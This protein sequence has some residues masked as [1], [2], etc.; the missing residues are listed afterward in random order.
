MKN[1][2]ELLIQIRQSVLWT[3]ILAILFLL[4]NRTESSMAGLLISM[5]FFL[6]LY[7]LFFSI[8]R[9]EIAARVKNWIGTDIRK[10][11]VFPVFLLILYC[12]Y[13]LLNGQSPLQGALAL[14]PYLIVFPLLLFVLSRHR[15][16]KIDWMDFTAFVIYLLLANF[17][18]VEPSGNLPFRGEELDSIYRI[19]L[20]VMAVYSF[21]II[22]GLDDI[23]F[24]PVLNWKNL[25]TAVWVWAAFYLF[26]FIVGYQINFIKIVGH[27][28]VNS[29]LL[30]KIGIT[31]LITFLHTA[32]FEEL[33]FRGILQNML[34]KRIAQ[35]KTWKIF[36]IIGFAILLP[37][38]FLVG[39]T[40]KGGMQWFPAF[41]VTLIFAAAYLIERSGKSNSGVYT[42]LA[43]TS[44]IFGLVHYHSGAIIYIGF[45]CL[46]GWAYGYTYIQ[47]KNVFY[48]ALVHTLV[49]SSVVIFGLE[50]VK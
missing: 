14:V 32:I 46:A 36:L 29:E 18:K 22:R 23:G 37:L 15:V 42:A 16:K 2:T 4:L 33:F 41:M 17:V 44:A 40:L 34:N 30:R 7:F 31:L 39:Y 13:L 3:T 10:V 20:M 28:T 24:F 43:I 47:T 26:V 48:S 45:A 19:A 49:N 50:F 38:A 6:I 21:S 27:D 35:A 9:K 8:G 5:P 11:I 12:I 1:T 25:W